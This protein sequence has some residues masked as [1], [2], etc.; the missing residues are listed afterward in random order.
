M[1]ISENLSLGPYMTFETSKLK[2]IHRW[3]HYKEGY[4][5]EIVEYALKQ[6]AVGHNSILLDPFCG[7]G[8]SLLAAKANGLGGMG[9]DAS[10]LA[11]FVSRVKCANY[12]KSEIEEA[13]DFLKNLFKARSEPQLKWDFELFSPRAAFPK[14]NLNDILY[15]REAIARSECGDKAKNL[16]L[17]ALVSILPQSSIIIKDGGVL[18]I[19]KRKSAM[20]AKEAFKRKVKQMF[21]DIEAAGVV[22]NEP[23]VVLGDARALPC[24][25]GSCD[26]IVTSPPY[27]NN[28][29]YSKVYGLELSLLTLDKETTKQ[30]RARSLRSFIKK[31]TE[32]GESGGV[33]EEVGDIGTRIPVVGAYFADMEQAI[34]E[35]KRVLKKGSSAYVV[36]SNSV[37]FQ[38]H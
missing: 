11:V 5:P 4:S 23:E 32:A 6:E 16:L 38:E 14:R 1:K 34:M 27:L 21:A 22:G 12:G 8:T 10:E 31:D 28:I 15:I 24:E 25:N 30:T 2:P 33:P 13:S 36:V 3:F 35:M 18:K 20:P 29:D 26:I 9:V 17:L 7:A 37:I 19:D